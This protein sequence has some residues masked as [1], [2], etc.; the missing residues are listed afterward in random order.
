[1]EKK[2][3]F[4]TSIPGGILGIISILIMTILGTLSYIY[5]PSDEFKLFSYVVSE[6]GVGEGALFFN[7]GL[8]SSGIFVI[9]F[10]FKLNI[11]FLENQ[12][13][14]LRV[15]TLI[16]GLISSSSYSLL[17]FFPLNIVVHMILVFNIFFIGM[18][19]IFILLFII[20]QE[21]K[22]FGRIIL[23]FV[24]TAYI[25]S[26]LSYFFTLLFYYDIHSQFEWAMVFLF[27]L[28]ILTHSA[29]LLYLNI[30]NRKKEKI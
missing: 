11:T 24:S 17:G 3:T 7:L 30:M 19:N 6:L 20:L 4:L 21:E 26:I 25:I 9:A 28:W 27:E 14:R 23:I 12:S 29:Y 8:I 10:F 2:Y 13:E 15:S 22:S 5:Y 18:I 1:M 16:L